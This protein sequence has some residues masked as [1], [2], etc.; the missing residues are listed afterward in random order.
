MFEPSRKEGIVANR[1]FEKQWI[2]MLFQLFQYIYIHIHIFVREG[3]VEFA[4]RTNK[5]SKVVGTIWTIWAIRYIRAVTVWLAG[6]LV[7]FGRVSHLSAEV[8][9]IIISF[10]IGAQG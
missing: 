10:E 1:G 6:W 4:H 3:A 7:R 2:A 5:A 9:K 8:G